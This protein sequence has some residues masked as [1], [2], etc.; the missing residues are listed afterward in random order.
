MKKPIRLPSALYALFAMA[1]LLPLP[2]AQAHE[3]LR[4]KA[5]LEAQPASATA[6]FELAQLQAQLGNL[7][8]ELGDAEH[9]RALFARSQSA[10]AQ[11]QDAYVREVLIAHLANELASSGRFDE[12]LRQL[13]RVQDSELWVKGAWKLIGKLAKA[14]Q[15]KQAAEL[16][17]RT[18]ARSRAVSAPLLRAE[19]LS[20]TGAAYRYVDRAR[21]ENLVYESYGMAQMLADP[22]ERGLMLNEAGAHLVDIGHRERAIEVFE[23]VDR[24]VAEIREPL[25]QAQVLAMVGGGQAEKNLRERAVGALDKGRAIAERL[26]AG[27][28]AWAVRSEIARNYGQS[29]RFE[30]GIA[31]AE[32]IRDPY[33]RI[34]GFIRIAKNMARTGQ[35]DAAQVLLQRCEH[36]AAS[37]SKPYLRATLLRKLA[38][39]RIDARQPD[40]AKALLRQAEA[41]IAA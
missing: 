34:E 21:G 29:H 2:A 36:E 39:E 31:V 20:G 30:P 40:A 18:E 16:L 11:V 26:P 25:Q 6:P 32:A 22:Y 3:D 19:L 27:E 4:L 23:A 41:A 33:H 1:A 9:A 17:A 38:S 35:R 28:A 10:A 37:V 24:L 8:Q 13:D 5:W 15:G 12:A 7:W 14:Q